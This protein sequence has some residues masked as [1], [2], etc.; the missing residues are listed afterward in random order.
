[1]QANTSKNLTI[2]LIL[3]LSML[4]SSL[5]IA[6]NNNFNNSI[7]RYSLDLYHQTKVES[8]NLFLSPLS[9]Y[10]LLLM[11]YEGSE[12]KTKQEFEKVLYLNSSDSLKN[13]SQHNIASKLATNPNF[14][15]YNAIWIDKNLPIKA[16]YSERVINKY[17]S[18]IKQTDFSNIQS[19]I[20]E[21]NNWV[22]DKTN[23]RIT[24]IV[25]V[26]TINSNVKVLL[27]N[28]VYFKAEW[29]NKFEKQQTKSELFYSNSEN[30]YKID[31]MKKTEKLQYFENEELQ[32][33]SKPYKDSTLSFCI[34]LP[35]KL[36]GIGEIEEKLNSEM[37]D[38]IINNTNYALTSLSIPKFS[39]E[40][41]YQLSESLKN[42]GLRTALSYEADFSGIT[43]T[44]LTLGSV[45][46]KTW[47]ELDEEKTEAVAATTTSLITGL[48]PSYKVFNADHP[49][50]FCIIDKSTKTILFMG[51]FT[52]P[53]GG[54]KIVENMDNLKTNLEKRNEEKTTITYKPDNLMYVVDKKII[55][56][57]ELRTINPADIE[58]INVI[59]DK[60]E[61]SN[62]STVQYD[63]IIEITLK[64][65]DN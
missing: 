18:E 1:M 23:H 56:Q 13:S 52:E 12:N 21:I 55:T 33:I 57:D 2:L 22:S 19:A 63:G 65:K 62:Y 7:N 44:P 26:Y 3:C 34:I 36:F 42:L 30:Q 6:Q 35:K 43:Q 61:I 40:F 8:E 24:E 45:V 15:V 59:K 11:A 14:K 58:S 20:S 51:R 27:S 10:F 31:F 46:H 4:A 54:V 41:D 50:V 49:F 9:T 64:K 48:H 47:F 16:E 28:A 37:F 17:S 39:L 38:K 25:N 5:V 32:L 53:V 60:E 29:L